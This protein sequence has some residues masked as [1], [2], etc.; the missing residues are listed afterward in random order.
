MSTY[1]GFLNQ[2][3]RR[4]IAEGLGVCERPLEMFQT[5]NKGQLAPKYKKRKQNIISYLIKY[6]QT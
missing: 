2:S 6:T 5:D 3:G 1:Q 4:H